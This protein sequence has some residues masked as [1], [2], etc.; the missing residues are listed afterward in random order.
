[1]TILT[2][3]QQRIAPMT[4]MGDSSDPSQRFN[5]KFMMYG[6]PVMFFFI[7]NN[8]SSGLVLYWTVFNVLTMIQQSL[9]TKHVIK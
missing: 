1:M 4:P 8:F 3:V 7:F 6:M 2:F 5:Q 9:M